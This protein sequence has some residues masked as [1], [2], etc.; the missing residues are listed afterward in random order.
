MSA[1]RS[2]CVTYW[3]ASQ[4]GST[5]L[6]SQSQQLDVC[7][8]GVA[9]RA[10]ELRPDAWG[11]LHMDLDETLLELIGGIYD[12]ALNPEM[13]NVILPRIGAFVGGSGGGLFSHDSTRR[14]MSIAY[15]FGTDPGY[16]RLY[17]EKYLTLDPMAW[18]YFVLD[19]GEVFSTSTI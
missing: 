16:R 9:P 18:S 13:W 3:P 8:E 1:S 14:S 17:V 7:P 12:S 4:A 2:R 15:E 5:T 11:R 19:V 6:V 10:F